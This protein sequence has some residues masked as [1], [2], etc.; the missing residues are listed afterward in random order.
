M[1]KKNDAEVIGVKEDVLYEKR[2]RK[3]YII[4]NK[5]EKLNALSMDMYRKIG[6]ILD[7]IEEDDDIRVV[8]LKGNGRAFSAGYDIS[9]EG[10][11]PILQEKREIEVSNSN[12]WKIWN[13]RKPFIAQLHKYCLGGAC[14]LALPCDYLIGSEDL[15]IGE[16]EIQ[17]GENPAFLLIPWVCGL[18]KAKELLLTGE[19][20]SGK[21][22]A[23]IGLITRAFP[24]EKLEEEVEKLADKLIK[25]SPPAL[26]MQKMGINRAFE[27]MGLKSSLDTWV[28]LALYFK[29][30]KTDEVIEFNR[31]VSEKGVKAALAWR[32]EYFNK[33]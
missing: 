10:D 18:R 21:E 24:E 3:A 22:A 5:P 17:F 1:S 25:I 26:Y 32:D 8:I 12:R 30:L 15:L 16:P 29:V 33:Q 20:I 19:K 2:G 14:E 28:D 6:T 27:I 23:E 31:I 11:I 13:S 7:E 4:L 9:Q